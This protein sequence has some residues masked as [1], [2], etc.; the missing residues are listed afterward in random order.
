[1]SLPTEFDGAAA[2]RR[3]TPEE[4]SR[5]LVIEDDTGMAEM[6][7]V[8]LSAAG[9][10]VT[11][12][13]SGREGLDLACKGSFDAVVLDLTLP[14][15][16]GLEVC[17]E[18][19]ID[20]QLPILILTARSSTRDVVIG[21]EAGADDYLT[22]PFA[23][24]ELLARV[25]AALRRS[26]AADDGIH[27][28]GQL[29]IDPAAFTVHRGDEPVHLSATEF[30][31]LLELVRRRGKAC[32]RESLLREVWDHDYLGDSRLI[33]MAV[34]RLRDRIEDDPSQPRLVVTVR[35]VGYRLEER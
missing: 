29:R 4:R 31:L 12:V 10:D 3:G 15:A 30:R 14:D 35:G 2:V 18:M 20:S 5:I 7:D 1:M 28:V 21:L 6:V 16:D 8:A 11:G 9:L 33:D 19:R 24:P 23:V 32:T 13:G 34:R 22:K 25:R 17:Q 26:S 27:V